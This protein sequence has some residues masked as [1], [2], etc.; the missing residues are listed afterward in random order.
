MIKIPVIIDCDPGHDDAIAL[1]LAFSSPILDIKGVTVVGGNQT[2]KKTSDN[3]LKILSFIGADVPVAL[4]AEGPLF[5][6]H[7]IQ[8]A[9]H[10]D[11]G[12]DGPQLPSATLKPVNLNAV[13]LM[14][15][16]ISES[17]EKVT[18]IPLGPLTNV[19]TFLMANPELITNIERICLM[20]G[21][22]KHG[23]TTP[24]AEFNIWQDPEAASVVFSAGIPLT[25]HGIDATRKG[26]LLQ[27]DIERFRSIG[28]VGKLVAELM[29]FF[30]QFARKKGLP[31]SVHDA[32]AVA[33][34]IDSSIY[35]TKAANVEI[36]LAGEKTKGCTVTDFRE[37]G[38]KDKNVDVVVGVNRT[39][40]VDM[41][42][43][44]FA[45]YN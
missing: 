38:K 15:K 26:Y 42:A 1:I 41:L 33:W 45:S 35:E 4:G 25:M 18:I 28:K 20:G 8:D 3:T 43:N 37:W 6:E 32:N 5:K 22:A 12:M 11:T 14:E 2:L 13:E 16:I 17:N 40:F 9:I 44:A 29:D 19:A 27:E 10:G 31:F 30:T 34:V 23:N 36:D 21:G 24:A 7:M 39:K